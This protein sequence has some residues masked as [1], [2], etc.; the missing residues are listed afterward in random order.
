MEMQISIIEQF[1]KIRI[2]EDLKFLITQYENQHSVV[3]AQDRLTDRGRRNEGTEI[4]PH[5][6]DQLILENPRK[7]D[8]QRI[9][10][11]A[12]DARPPEQSHAKI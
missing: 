8:G 12:S 1:Y 4:T 9:I 10:F 5:I 6:C 11:S 7:C 2:K 3:L